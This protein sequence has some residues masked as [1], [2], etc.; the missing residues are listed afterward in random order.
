MKKFLPTIMIPILMIATLY[1]IAGRLDWFELLIYLLTYAVVFTA[2]LLYLKLK[3]P[4]LLKERMTARKNA[5]AWDVK[6]LLVYRLLMPVFFITAALDAG[7]FQFSVVPVYLKVIAY[8]VLLLS[9]CISFWAVMVNNYLSSFVRIQ[10]DRGHVV[11]KD[12]PYRFV[13]HPMYTGIVFTYP[14]TALF[15]GSYFA[16]IP[17]VLITLVF[18]VRTSLEDKTLQGKLMGYVEYTDEVKYRLIPFVW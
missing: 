2:W 14:S 10:E 16:L 6:I 5:E 3:A 1:M 18:I 4:D 8:I 11:V 15:L 12:G 7:R 13:R 17:A 9:Y